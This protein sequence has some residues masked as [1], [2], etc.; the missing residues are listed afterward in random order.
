MALDRDDPSVSDD[1]ERPL[2][3]EGVERTRLA[4]H[5]LLTL[6][7]VID[8]IVSSPLKR[9]VQTAAIAA[10]ALGV[11]PLSLEKTELL[12]PEAVPDE[13]LP[14]LRRWLVSPATGTSR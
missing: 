3:A 2:T 13:I 11:P 12:L 6:G 4:A 7:A 10:E 8:H 9:A 14:L 5:G 1:A